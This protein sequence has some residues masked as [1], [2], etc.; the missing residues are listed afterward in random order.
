MKYQ[1]LYELHI[2]REARD[3]YQIS[4]SL[5]SSDGRII[6]TNFD[7]V[8]EVA[9]NINAQ[10][11]LVNNPQSAILAGDLNALGLIDEIYHLIIFDYKRQNPGFTSKS[12]EFLE[13]DFGIENVS[14]LLERFVEEF[15]P[16][17]VY[18]GQLTASQYLSR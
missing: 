4:D 8:R 1:L 6:F 2:S 15:P 17:A 12:L 11:D 18:H 7:S 16:L 5:F 9:N 10:R 13:R 3:R 14:I